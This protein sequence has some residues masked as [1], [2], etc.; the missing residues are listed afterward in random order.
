MKKLTKYNWHLCLL[1]ILQ[2]ILNYCL[3]TFSIIVLSSMLLLPL[4]MIIFI[5]KYTFMR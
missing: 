5:I 3:T 1:D 4:F 2:L